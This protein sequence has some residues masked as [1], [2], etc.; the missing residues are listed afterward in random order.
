MSKEPRSE[1]PELRQVRI[2]RVVVDPDEHRRDAP[3]LAI[4]GDFLPARPVPY[5]PT[6]KQREGNMSEPKKPEDCDGHPDRLAIS[7]RLAV[8]YLRDLTMRMGR[9][10]CNDLELPDGLVSRAELE[11]MVAIVNEINP[12]DDAIGADSLLDW[13]LV[14]AIAVHLERYAE[15]RKECNR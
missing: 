9:A 3:R 14:D 8:H 15:A 12:D 4:T 2:G 1:A 5:D 6:D 13:M 11:E 10:G 7:L